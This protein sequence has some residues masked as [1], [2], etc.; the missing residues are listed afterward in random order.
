MT[1][2][3]IADFI[4][5]DRVEDSE[6]HPLVVETNAEIQKAQNNNKGTGPVSVPV[7]AVSEPAPKEQE[8]QTFT[9]RRAQLQKASGVDGNK[10]V[11][12]GGSGPSNG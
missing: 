5:A 2:Q 3:V 10:G 1:D 11:E 4:P 8:W 6:L 12:G 9:R 7:A